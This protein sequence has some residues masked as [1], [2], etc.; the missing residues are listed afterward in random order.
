MQRTAIAALGLLLAGCAS[1]PALTDYTVNSGAQRGADQQAL[2]F[3]HADLSL[4]IDPDSRSLRG[5]AT[6][7]FGTRAPSTST[8]TATCPSTPSR[9]TASRSPQASGAIRTAS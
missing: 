8:W 1:Q 3:D 2:V 6:L 9:S 5:D 7:T 4:R